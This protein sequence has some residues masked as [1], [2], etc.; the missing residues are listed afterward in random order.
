MDRG[1]VEGLDADR[2]HYPKKGVRPAAMVRCCACICCRLF[3]PPAIQQRSAGQS[4]P[5]AFAGL[6]PVSRNSL[7]QSWSDGRKSCR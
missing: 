6:N 7:K 4:D 1:A 2:R 5:P 3:D